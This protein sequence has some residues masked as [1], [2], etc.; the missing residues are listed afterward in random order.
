LNDV[1]ISTYARANLPVLPLTVAEMDY[2]RA[3]GVSQSVIDILRQGRPVTIIPTNQPV[4]VT[5][6]PEVH[7][8]LKTANE[9]YSLHEHREA[10]AY[11]NRV[12][13]LDPDNPDAWC[14]KATSEEALHNSASAITGFSTFLKLPAAQT[15]QYSAWRSY[16]ST[17]LR[18]LRGW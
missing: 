16:A 17:R 1:V 5:P 11:C 2:L 14:I 12:L 18:A 13:K 8:L 9:K 15:P 7:A 10:I 6:N 3:R 4:Y